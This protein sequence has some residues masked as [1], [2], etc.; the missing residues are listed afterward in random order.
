M[1]SSCSEDDTS[2]EKVG[3][4]SLE[5]KRGREMPYLICGYHFRAAE[6]TEAVNWFAFADYVY[7]Y[8]P[9]ET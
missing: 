6:H 4:V 3:A 9:Q 8:R 7:V 2:F 1:V 5:K